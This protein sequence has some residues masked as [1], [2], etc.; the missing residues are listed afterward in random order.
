MSMLCMGTYSVNAQLISIGS[1]IKA[2]E[3]KDAWKAIDDHFNKGNT[4]APKERPTPSTNEKQN[5]N[6]EDKGG[7]KGDGSNPQSYLITNK[8]LETI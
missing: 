8:E 2:N 5:N 4:P 3:Q 6:S 1:D 7:N